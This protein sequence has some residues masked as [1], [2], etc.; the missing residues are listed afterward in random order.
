MASL[1]VGTFNI[2]YD[3]PQD[4]E[5]GWPLRLPSVVALLSELDCDVFGLQEVLPTQCAQLHAQ[6]P[7]YGHVG[8]G[9]REG[10][11]DEMCP[12][13]YRKD[14]LQVREVAAMNE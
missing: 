1:K 8:T 13:F 6:L 14:R 11:T 2:R 5:D 9:R 12:V 3:N 10:N 7:A 4:G